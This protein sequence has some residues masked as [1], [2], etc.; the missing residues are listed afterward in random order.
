VNGY[1]LLSFPAEERQPAIGTEELRFPIVPEAVLDLKEMATNLAFDLRTF[2]AIVEVEIIM[3]CLAA[4]TDHLLR[5][6]LGGIALRFN[7][8]KRFTVRCLVLG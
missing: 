4:K 3:G 6:S 5:N 8:S 2:L 7:R 1:F